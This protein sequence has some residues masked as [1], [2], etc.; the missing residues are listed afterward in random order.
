MLAFKVLFKTVFND[1]Q[2][3]IIIQSHTGVSALYEFYMEFGYAY[4]RMVQIL[5][6]INPIPKEE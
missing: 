5:P 6:F 3:Q 4:T 1:T 2:H